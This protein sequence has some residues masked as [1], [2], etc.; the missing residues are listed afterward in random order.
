MIERII[1]EL[2]SDRFGRVG[3]IT[4][5]IVIVIGIM[6]VLMKCLGVKIG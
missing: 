5:I 3:R 1:E 6:W 2:G 4:L